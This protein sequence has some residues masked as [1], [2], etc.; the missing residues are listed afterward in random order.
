VAHGEALGTGG[1][2]VL[3]ASA[4]I[5]FAKMNNEKSG[6]LQLC[7]ADEGLNGYAKILASI[8]ILEH[9]NEAHHVR[10]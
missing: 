9:R 2:V 3:P 6:R 1:S 4:R 7:W 5:V 10:C 8:Y